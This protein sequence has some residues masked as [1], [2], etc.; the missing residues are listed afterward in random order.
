MAIA[1]P[2]SLFQ[3]TLPSTLSKLYTV[4]TSYIIVKEI[5]ISNTSDELVTVSLN[6]INNGDT[7]NISNTILSDFALDPKESIFIS[8]L[9]SVLETYSNIYAKSS[10]DNV[11]G[12]SVSGIEVS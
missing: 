11:V 3:A 7:P 1:R 8:S 10:I 4:T 6:L 9:S 2:K 12:L 5:I